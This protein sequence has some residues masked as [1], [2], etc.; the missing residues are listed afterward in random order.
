MKRLKGKR[1][2]LL[3]VVSSIAVPLLAFDW[4]PF[5]SPETVKWIMLANVLGNIWLRFH[6]NTPVFDNGEK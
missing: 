3:N 1:T 5:F 2:I 4:S 6:T